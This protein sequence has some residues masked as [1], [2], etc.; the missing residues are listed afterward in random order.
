[1][2]PFTMAVTTLIQGLYTMMALVVLLDVGSPTFNLEGVPDWVGLQAVIAG[3]VL[4]VTALAL[5]VIMHTTS[6]RLF[7][8]QKDL[9]M[10]G[11]LVSD[12]VQQRF[13]EIGVVRSSPGGPTYAEI[14]KVETENRVRRAGAFLHGMEYQVM[15]RA[16]EV[17][18][19]LQVYRDQLPSGPW[20][21]HPV[22]RPC[23]HSAVLGPSNGPGSGHLRTVPDHPVSDVH[24]ER[25]RVGGELR[26]LPR[27]G[28]PIRCGPNSR[29]RNA[30]GSP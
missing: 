17:Y 10:F 12:S 4:I 13:S 2:R 21:H 18:R 14:L 23:P 16:P 19:M 3:T 30:R 11:M 27:A 26:R 8:G 9:W 15:I 24:A 1:M 20:P 6:R 22:G 29:L 25:P 28:F 5:G 7:H